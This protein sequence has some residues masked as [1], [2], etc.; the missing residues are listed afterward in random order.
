MLEFSVAQL[1]LTESCVCS[2][3][4]AYFWKLSSHHV[5]NRYF[6]ADFCVASASSILHAIAICSVL[7]LVILGQS[8]AMPAS[9][10]FDFNAQPM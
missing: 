4:S 9:S 2:D 3:V 8:L 7:V 10:P 6:R 1:I 5:L